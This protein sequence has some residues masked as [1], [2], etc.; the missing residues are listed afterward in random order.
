MMC[1]SVDLPEPDGPT[2]AT[3][4]PSRDGERDAVQRRR[5]AAGVGLAHVGQLED[6]GHRAVTTGRALAQVAL[7]LDV[8][9]GVQ[10]RLDGDDPVRAAVDDLDGEAAALARQ[11]R[12][13][14]HREHAGAAL[15]GEADV[16]RRLVEP[17]A[18]RRAGRAASI[19]T[20]I[21]GSPSSSPAGCSATLPTRVIRPRAV[22]PSAARRS[23]RR[24]RARAAGAS[25]RGR[26]SRAARSRTA[27][28]SSRPRRSAGRPAALASPIRVAPAPEHD[29]APGQRA[30]LVEPALLLE[31]L[32]R[33][34]RRPVPLVVDVDVAVG[35]VAERAQVALEL[36]DVVAVVH[37]G[38][39]SRQAGSAP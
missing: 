17:G 19:V 26:R 9:V 31:A 21:V 34:G 2:T 25:R 37:P 16:D 7:D 20:S 22:R 35:V 5:P 18:A 1:S 10:A 15:D 24:P 4:S 38:V 28:A 8:V 6:G 36:A 39:K 14:R 3:S 11:Q 27:S 32:D 23:R 30:V 13:D 12:L 29:L 33:G